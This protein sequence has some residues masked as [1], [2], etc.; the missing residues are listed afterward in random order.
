MT[1]LGD[2]RERVRLEVVGALRGSLEL[3]ATARVIN[4]SQT[5]ALIESPLAMPVD[6]TQVV[7]FTVDGE[8]V[9]VEARVRHVRQA[10]HSS[11]AE[12]LVGVEF[13]FVPVALGQR[14]EQLPPETV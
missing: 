13:M 10:P 6:S 1:S 12:Y 4:I 5:G 3:S 8:D 11:K 7:H 2:R 14:I 9:P